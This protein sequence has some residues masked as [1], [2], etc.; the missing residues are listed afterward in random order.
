MS[1]PNSVWQRH[2]QQWEQVGSPLRPNRQ[3]RALM[4]VAVESFFGE[5]LEPKPM[6]LLG[7]TPELIDLG[8]QLEIPLLAFDQ[9][10]EMIEAIRL[11]GIP[12]SHRLLTQARWQQLP[13]PEQSLQVVVGD[14]SLNV[15]PQL[16]DYSELLQEQQRLL[17]ATGGVVLR[18]FIR[19]PVAE[20]LEAV[21]EAVRAGEIGSFHAFK[22]RLAMSLSAPPQFSVAVAEIRAALNAY[23]PERGVLAKITGWPLA[24]IET[25]DA[26][27]EVATRYSFP[28]LAA[29]LEQTAPFFTLQRIDQGD[30]ELADRCPILCWAR[31]AAEPSRR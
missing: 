25:I 8:R 18:C 24:Q 29:L 12:P 15:L 30:Y 14:G 31:L 11:M 20:G 26:Y 17:T 4:Q 19:P 16:S 5:A 2:A 3:D 23:F 28:T 13:L 6:G 27:R 10:R 7:V 21:V 1:L 9:S 22:W